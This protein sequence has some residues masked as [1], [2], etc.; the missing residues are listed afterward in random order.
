MCVF[1]LV[2]SFILLSKNIILAALGPWWFMRLTSN[3]LGHASALHSLSSSPTPSHGNPLWYG[4]MQ[5]RFLAWVLPPQETGQTFQSLHWVQFPS[6][7]RWYHKN[8]IEMSTW[9]EIF[10]FQY[11]NSRFAF[12]KLA[13]IHKLPGERKAC[14][15][16]LPDLNWNTNMYFV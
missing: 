12:S 10:Y 5:V 16:N 1:W 13:F 4:P 8:S 11:Q 14:L 15:V 6:T 9:R 7:A 3:L 2:V